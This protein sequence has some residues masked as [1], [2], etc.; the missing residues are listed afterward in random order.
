M[1]ALRARARRILFASSLALALAHLAACGN[2][3]GESKQA[4]APAA[5]PVAAMKVATRRVPISME[6][7]GQAEG[8]REVEIRAR[9]TGILLKRVY[10]EG[11]PVTAGTLM[12]EIDPAPFALAVQEA[13][14]AL[15]Q[16]K[17]K[18]DL[19]ATDARR[20]EPLVK[21]KAISQR[22]YDNA[23]AA[24]RTSEAAIAS[25]EAKLQ[26]AEL[27]L[28][29]T[30]ITAPISGVTGRAQRSEGSLI[31]AGTDSALLTTLTQVNP[32]WVRFSLAEPD[33][34]RIR[35]AE[36]G[37]R[38]Q[39]VDEQNQVIAENGKLNFAA[40]TVD[41]K[42]GTV[43]L[44]AEF[45]NPNGK[46]LPG[47]FAKVRILAGEQNAILVPQSAILQ[48]E[49]SRVVMTVG[50]DGKAVQRPVKIAS[51]IGS[52]TVIT[53]GLSDGDV[54]I[55]DNLVKVRPGTPVQPHEAAAAAKDG[56]KPDATKTSER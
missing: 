39:L 49:Q 5:L 43:Q 12:F 37:A 22:D 17:V 30:R 8:S 53:A 48:S 6:A 18:R 27:N 13:K 55:L 1:T 25:A 28:S 15:L 3:G 9:V 54:V 33:F 21:E 46:W 24:E 41:T 50:P 31:S 52:D 11:A 14:A 44:R 2:A 34:T 4:A 20:L 26:D 32:I 10:E 42:L 35:G 23:V 56:A 38:V 19:A 40:S 29:Y 45:P 51:W 36:R 7:V 47:Q 16:E